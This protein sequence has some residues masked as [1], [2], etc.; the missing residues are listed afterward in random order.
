[1]VGGDDR[2]M[3]GKGNLLIKDGNVVAMPILGPLSVLLNEVVPGF[4]YQP[5]RKAT[6]DFN[7]GKGVISTRNILIEGLGFNMIGHGDIDYLDNQMDMSMRLN[8]KGPIGLVTYLVSKTFEY[9]SVGSATHPKWR[10]KILPKLGPK[11]PGIQP[12]ASP[13]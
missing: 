11:A 7:V 10:P 1:M 9:E 12:A 13:E 6:A 3:T 8:I 5:A 4:G 2:S